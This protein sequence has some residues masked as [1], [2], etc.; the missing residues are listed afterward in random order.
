MG[1]VGTAFFTKDVA[2]P[3]IERRCLAIVVAAAITT[4]SVFAVKTG[5]AYDDEIFNFRLVSANNVWDIIDIVN[6][7]DVHPPGSYIINW[8][9]FKLLSSWSAT[10]IAGG[11]FNAFSLTVFFW[12]AQPK[13]VRL[14]SIVLALV[15]A[16]ESTFVLWGAS[17][18]WYA[19]FNP[20]FAVALGITLFS[21]R[22]IMLR[23][24]VVGVAGTV[25]LYLSYAAFCAIPVLVAV[26]IGRI[27]CDLR[28]R[29]IV[30]LGATALIVSFACLPQLLVLA[31]VQIAATNGQVAS[32]AIAF[33]Q[34][35]TTLV[36]GNA[37]FPIGLAPLLFALIMVPIV[38]TFLASRKFSAVDKLV[39]GGLALGVLC[40][41]LTGLGGKG[42]NA[43]FLLP[44]VA[45]VIASSI[46]A[47]P[48]FA[49]LIGGAA[50]LIYQAIGVSNVVAHEG[51]A[52]GSYNTD[53][54][55]VLRQIVRWEETCDKGVVV[56]NHDVVLS[57]QLDQ[58]GIAQSSPYVEP[59]TPRVDLSEGECVIAVKS[60]RGNFSRQLVERLYDALNTQLLESHAK[61]EIGRDRDAQF[62]TWV[63]HEL[64]APYYVEL[65]LF[66][67]RDRMSLQ[68]W[69][70]LAAA[71]PSGE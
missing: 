56:L 67:A 63:A 37:I 1:A 19:Y 46:N 5:F 21:D 28:R 55:G 20:L 58:V 53:Y 41:S 42:R 59:T 30:L 47:L 14:Q 9:L 49:A 8:L 36:F 27:F 4:L 23:T 25:L 71:S 17:V 34:T 60:Y 11:V 6:S 24:V 15:L 12:L 32:P 45:L 50:L 35:A 26:H 29:D 31:R 68:G 61:V 33:V 57:Y 10:K 3:E 13:L 18:R 38:T 39:I 69:H 65:E 54:V 43:V 62:K 66:L 52:K 64:F 48:R 70:Q 22:S 51:T 44:L 16:T 7:K 40:L 2:R